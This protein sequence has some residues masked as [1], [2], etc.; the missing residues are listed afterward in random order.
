M[1]FIIEERLLLDIIK[2]KEIPKVING[3]ERSCSA[4]R[5]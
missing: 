5:Y 2:K 1:F 4:G 3:E